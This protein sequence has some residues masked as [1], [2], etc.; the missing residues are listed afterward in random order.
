MAQKIINIGIQG[1]DGTGDSIRTSFQKV[2]DN[3]SEIYAFFGQGGTIKFSNLSDAPNSYGPNTLIACYIV[4][5]K[6]RKSTRLNSSHSR[7][8]RMP[9]SA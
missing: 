6:D 7:A 2:N 8:S 3:F 5:G 1:N 4:T 9:S